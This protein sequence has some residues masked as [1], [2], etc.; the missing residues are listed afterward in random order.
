MSVR[1]LGA[2]PGN[3]TGALA[4]VGAGGELLGVEDMPHF[5]I[6]RGKSAKAQLNIPGLVAVLQ[7]WRPTHVFVE[8]VG[9]REGE[10]PS[11]SFN[12]GRGFGA[13]EAVCRILGG[14]Y[15][16]V[17]PHVWKSALKLKRGQ[18]KDPSRLRATELWPG[19]A[20]LFALKKHDG[21]AEAALI[22]EYG[23]QSLGPLI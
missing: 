11:T 6:Q 15:N 9:A 7:E 3:K 1:I 4:L 13:L 23:R 5:M 12:F 8:A 22:A 2:D 18:G 19:R 10:A 16:D 17:P 20:G 14:Q 21:R